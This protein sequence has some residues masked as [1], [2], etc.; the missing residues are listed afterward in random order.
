MS[1]AKDYPTKNPALRGKAEEL[2]QQ[3]LEV[4]EDFSGM[5]SQDM[6]RLVHELRVHQLE[7]EIQNDELRRIQASLEKARDRYSFLYD[8]A[9]V[10]YFTV[11]DKDIITEANLTAA[12]L[13]DQQRSALIG[14]LFSRYIQKEDQRIWYLHR[15]RLLESVDNQSFHLRLVPSDGTYFHA[16]LECMR[17]LQGQ[18]EAD[19]IRIAAIDISE[20]KK[21]E[22]EKELYQNQ[23]IQARKMEAIGTLAGGIAHDFNNLL[24]G[25]QG[26]TS[27]MS[28]Q[29]ESSHPCMEHLAA[30][31]DYIRGASDLT[32]QL[33]GI[34]KGGKYEVRPIDINETVSASAGMFARTKKEIRIHANLHVPPPVIEADRRQIEQVLLNLY[35][36]AWQAMPRGGEIRLETSLVDLDEAFCNAHAMRPGRF[37]KISV[38]DT[39]SGMD[40]AT[41]KR[42]F[43]PFFTTKEKGRGTGLGLA[44]A[45]GIV[46]NHAGTITV[47]SEIDRG[48]TFFI[49][50]PLSG[51][52]AQREAPHREGLLQGTET[53]LLVDDEKMITDVTRAMLEKQG[54]RVIVA[55]SGQQA[56]DAVLQNAG[57]IDLVMLDMIM[58][59]MDGGAT[60]DRIRELEPAMPVV[61]SSGYAIN[62]L[63]EQ[64]L[65]RGCN[66]FLQK[67]FNISALSRKIRETLEAVK[68]R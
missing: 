43:D 11:D 52:V 45:Y 40:A 30:I 48:A 1:M 66:G 28:L 37:V 53:I 68:K 2:L 25:I 61:L 17:V 35:I 14:R 44:S 42:I 34:A 9:P 23:L 32:R 46:K 6:A 8:F 59:G 20:Q 50:L 41:C 7:L 18:G 62:G 60:F 5:S 19:R 27:L 31:K 3:R 10:A 22:M 29:L 55:N 36:N 65:K 4:D 54:Y 15:N 49:F 12:T 39:G 24:M 64:I 56:I 63:A 16:N 47:D 67:P 13:L 38:A 21:M 33:L 51:R 26:R 58:P 57:G